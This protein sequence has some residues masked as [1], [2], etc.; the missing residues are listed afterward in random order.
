MLILHYISTKINPSE[1][2]ERMAAKTREEKGRE[3]YRAGKVE[4][5][6]GSKPEA[7]GEFS[8]EGSGGKSYSVY[9]DIAYRVEECECEDYR[10]NRLPCKHIFAARMLR[11]ELMAA[12]PVSLF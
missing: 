5:L 11:E 3:L 10:R 1:R 6:E 12:E 9:L 7:G 8:V 4:F 2:T